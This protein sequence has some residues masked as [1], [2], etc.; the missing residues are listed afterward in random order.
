MSGFRVGFYLPIYGNNT[1]IIMKIDALSL[2]LKLQAQT[3]F[4]SLP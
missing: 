1:W 4:V 3:E 2:G